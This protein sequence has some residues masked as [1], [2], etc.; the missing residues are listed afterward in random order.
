MILA[1]DIHAKD[2]RLLLAE[3]STI[4][5]MQII[6]MQTLYKMRLMEQKIYVLD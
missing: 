1:S 6:K 5:N 3:G 4:S 2:G